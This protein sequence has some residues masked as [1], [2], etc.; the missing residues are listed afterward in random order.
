[1]NIE[2]LPHTS[3]IGSSDKEIDLLA[4][5]AFPQAPK[6]AK[7]PSLN[8]SLAID[9]SGSM[10]MN[11]AFELA[12]QAALGLLSR[13]EDSDRIAVVLYNGSPR[14]VLPSCPASEAKRQLPT[15]LAGERANGSTALHAGWLSAANQAAPFVNQYDVSRILL[16]SDGQATD[17]K[18]DPAELREETFQLLAAGISTSTYGLGLNFNETLMTEM[19]AGAPA[20]Y[21]QDAD[22]LGPYFEADFDLLSQTVAP[23]V[24]LRVEALAD[25][26]PVNVE[27][28]NG[29]SL[30]TDG[31]WSLPA[32]VSGAESWA[33]LQVK[34]DPANI[35]SLDINAEWIWRDM[36]GGQNTHTNSLALAKGR[37]KKN[38][39][40]VER[41]A[42]AK[43]AKMAKAAA[44]AARIGDFAAAS[45][46]VGLMRGLSASNA[47]INSVSDN[48]DHLIHAR[49][50]AS[51]A[52][53]ALYSSTTMSTRVAEVGEQAHA[54]S[55]DRFGLRKAVQG[56]HDGKTPGDK[57]KR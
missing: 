35:K 17:G 11:N 15:L 46:T 53:E 43:A 33:A 3:K 52:K 47:Y 34:I 29:Y 19:A 2:L 44:E 21:A 12:K 42:E 41:C 20:R 48:L 57:E 4:R 9:Q 27:I 24:K 18:R 25:G 51:L 31:Y 45:H 49:D 10:S 16:L 28:I 26:E 5:I 23:I 50:G 56:K 14:V 13:L 30:G 36:S 22:Q 1:M 8:L 54:M 39:V 37:G 55:A 6:A 7:R 38:T 40:V 32:G